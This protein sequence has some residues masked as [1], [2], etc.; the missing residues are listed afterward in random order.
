MILLLALTV[1]LFTTCAAAQ[2][3]VIELPLAAAPVRLYPCAGYCQL[4]DDDPEAASVKAA[5][6]GEHRDS[7][8]YATL[9]EYSKAKPALV[10]SNGVSLPRQ[11]IDSLY[12]AALVDPL[13]PP[14]EL[15]ILSAIMESMLPPAQIFQN[16]Q[17]MD[18]RSYI[19]GQAASFDFVLINEAHH[20]TQHRTFTASLLEDMYRQHGFRYLA[21]EALSRRDTI[22]SQRGFANTGSGITKKMGRET[23]QHRACQL[24]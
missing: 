3:E 23:T 24:S 21:L 5:T 12:N 1:L 10:G 22:L 18:A 13:V 2:P 16:A 15:A 14:E 4:A 9:R 19:L 7:R 11:M 8:Y 17:I 6:C 20:A